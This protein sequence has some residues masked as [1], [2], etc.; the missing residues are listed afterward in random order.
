MGTGRTIGLGMAAHATIDCTLS[1]AQILKRLVNH[2]VHARVTTRVDIQ[3]LDVFAAG[4]VTY[5]MLGGSF[6][7][8]S[9]SKQALAMQIERW[10]FPQCSEMARRSE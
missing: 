5:V 8:S 4:V 10:C 7:F 9:K 6:P 1:S 2:G 3:K